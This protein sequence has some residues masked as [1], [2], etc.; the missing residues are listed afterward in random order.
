MKY[1]LLFLLCSTSFALEVRVKN[2]EGVPRIHIDD[3]P[4]RPRFFYGTPSSRKRDIKTGETLVEIDYTAVRDFDDRFT[5]QFRVGRKASSKMA[6]DDISLVDT[7]TGEAIISKVDFEGGE[8]DFTSV[9]RFWPSLKEAPYATLGVVDGTGA[10][11][12][13]GLL[14]T[15]EVPEKG[16]LGHDFHFYTAPK[17]I[18]LI[19]GRTYKLSF[20]VKSDVDTWVWLRP[21]KQPKPGETFMKPVSDGH[22]E[23]QLRLA[24][25]ADTAFVSFP[26]PFPWPEDENIDWHE[27]DSIIDY[28]L[29]VS[30]NA[31]LVPRLDVSPPPWW[32]KENP[33]ELMGWAQ[34]EKHRRQHVSV[35][36]EKWLREARKRLADFIERLEAKYPDNIAGYHLNTGE[37]FYPGANTQDFHGF[38]PCEQAA[39]K[40]WLA[41][42]YGSDKALQAAWNQNNLTLDTVSAPSEERREQAPRSGC[43]LNPATSQDLIDFNF[44]MQD[45]MVDGVLSLLRVIR[46]TTGGKKLSLVFYGYALELSSLPRMQSSSGHMAMRKM[47]ASPDVDIICSPISYIDRSLGEASHSMTCSESVLLAGKLWLFEDDTSTHFSVES[48]T[49]PGGSSRTN[50]LWETRQVLLRNSGQARLRNYAG[51]Y[52]DIVPG[53]WFD[54]PG[55]WSDL[56]A[57]E[58]IAPVRPYSG[59]IA[60]LLD[61]RSNMYSLYGNGLTSPL[62]SQ[63]RR[64]YPRSGTTFGQYYLDDFVEGKVPGKV[65]VF[66]NTWALDDNQRRNITQH[67]KGR[68]AIW[69]CLP[70]MI[71]L[72][73]KTVAATNVTALTGYELAPMNDIVP[74]WEVK[75]TPDGLALG[76]PKSWSTGT[77]NSPAP[78]HSIVTKPG[79][80]VLATWPNGT[81]AVVLRKDS[82]FTATPRVSEDLLKVACRAVGAWIYTDSPCAFFQRDGFVLLHG[83][84][85]GPITLNFPTSRN[86]SDLMTGEKL[87]EKSPS[88]TID[89]KRGETRILM[90]K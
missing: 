16:R 46:E 24:A 4:V 64:A 68:F 58:R 67:L 10:N 2:A 70:G 7:V 43:L 40:R 75:A 90:A 47:L 5:L 23:S 21:F 30:P 13:K 57:L 59:E 35:S 26:C 25:Q 80:R 38:S 9:F 27:V 62:I 19:K 11:G 89:L 61:E 60:S 41:K 29:G 50:S 53:G 74:W 36:S 63:G 71:D 52:M 54:D 48:R 49:L 32:L 56:K 65:V 73:A 18:K 3:V 82:L 20:W 22:Y 28:A 66:Q 33:D 34:P 81:A 86:W 17:N 69:C 12:S 85:D 15:L 45:A 51:W 77:N 87:S 37:W 31:K 8:Q 44:F 6:F 39:F 1:L 79:D 83:T 42:K 76:L 72:D 84:Q 14:Q 88:L 55:I 78:V